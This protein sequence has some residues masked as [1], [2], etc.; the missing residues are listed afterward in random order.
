MSDQLTFDFAPRVDTPHRVVLSKDDVDLLDIPTAS[1]TQACLLRQKLVH[2]LKLS[3]RHLV[4]WDVQY[5]GSGSSGVLDPLPVG[6]L[7]A[8]GGAHVYRIHVCP[9]LRSTS[10]D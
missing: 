5:G 4:D 9:L 2:Q 1:F 3:P 6:L 10:H 7:P 8:F